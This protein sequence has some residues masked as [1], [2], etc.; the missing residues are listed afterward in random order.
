ML[1]ILLPVLFLLKMCFASGQYLQATYSFVHTPDYKEAEWTGEPFTL[2]YTYKIVYWGKH[3]YAF[4]QL[5]ELELYPDGNMQRVFGSLTQ[6]KRI[7]AKPYQFVEWLDYDSMMIKNIQDNPF[8]LPN[9]TCAGQHG[10]WKFGNDV[11][12]WKFDTEIKDINGIACQRA[13]NF[14]GEKVYWDVWFAPEVVVPG[15]PLHMYNLPGLM[16]E[17]EIPMNNW[18]FTLQSL[19]MLDPNGPKPYLPPCV[20]DY[21]PYKGTMKAVKTTK[22]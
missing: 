6:S 17:G 16:V 9:D 22:H 8:S 18:K 19:E 12:Q 5:Q 7:Y 11:E 13:K 1:R 10:M 15:S 21:F 20:D 3:V 4:A 14:V 2:H